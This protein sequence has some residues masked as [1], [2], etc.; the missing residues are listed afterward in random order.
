MTWEV[1]SEK[2]VKEAKLARVTERKKDM[3]WDWSGHASV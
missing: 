2:L 1:G 3:R